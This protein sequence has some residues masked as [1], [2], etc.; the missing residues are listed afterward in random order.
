MDVIVAHT[1]PGALAAK[2]AAGTIP[3]LMTNAGDPVGSHLVASLAKP[4]GNITGL[5]M[6]NVELG[7]KRVGLLREVVPGLTRVFVLWN[8]NNDG[9]VLIMKNTELAVRTM[10]VQLHSFEVRRPG[11]LEHVFTAIPGGRGSALMVVEDP[12]TLDHR[13]QVADFAVRNRLPAVYGLAAYVNA[14]GLLS[15]GIHLEDLF[16][17]SAYYVDKILKGTKPSDL[18]VEHPRSSSW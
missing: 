16:R 9:N 14:G 17:R 3:V 10:G 12:I 18:P 15:Y 2:Q 6:L 5:S 8:P 11:D 4:G 7:G 13:N 1:M